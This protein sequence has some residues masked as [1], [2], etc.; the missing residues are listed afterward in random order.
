[1]HWKE[2]VALVALVAT[3]ACGGTE[4]DSGTGG[5]TNATGGTSGTPLSPSGAQTF[6]LGCMRPDVSLNLE[7]ELAVRLSEPFVRGTSSDATFGPAVTLTEASTEALIDAGVESIDV[8]SMS[9]QTRLLG[10]EPTTMTTLL[11]DA[12]I[13]DFDLSVDPDDD[14]TPGP[15][16]FELIPITETVVPLGGADTVEF[17]ISAVAISFGDF[18]VPE[19]CVDSQSLVGS[20]LSFPVSSN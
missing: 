9:V 13:E 14:G 8:T 5:E 15:H 18:S 16:R 3:T 11:A 10:A 4:D 7:I 6:E 19:S 2:L 12:P 17:A 20:P 1:M